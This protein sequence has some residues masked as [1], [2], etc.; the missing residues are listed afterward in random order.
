MPDERYFS[1][2]SAESGS[3]VRRNRALN[4]CPWVRSLNHSPVAVIHSPAAIVAAWADHGYKITMSACFGAQNAEA[5]LD[6]VVG[7]ALDETG[8]H[9]L[10]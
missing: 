7:D 3:E 8:Q 5:V 9:F 10:G 2:P 4:C 1:M 6:I